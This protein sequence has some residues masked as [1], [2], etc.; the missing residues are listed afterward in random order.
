MKEASPWPMGAAVELSSGPR[1]PAIGEFQ[2]RRH[3]AEIVAALALQT[4]TPPRCACCDRPPCGSR[5]PPK[6]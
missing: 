3:V 2:P 4:D 5:S 6:V 1:G